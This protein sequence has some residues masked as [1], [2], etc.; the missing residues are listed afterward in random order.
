MVEREHLQRRVDATRA[1][2]ARAPAA[3]CGAVGR[4]PPAVPPVVAEAALDTRAMLI[5]VVVLMIALPLV[6]AF[7]IDFALGSAA[8]GLTPETRAFWAFI[9]HF[10]EARWSLWPTAIAAIGVTVALIR[11][12]DAPWRE[13]ARRA[14][15][16][17][18]FVFTAIAAPGLFVHVI[19]TIVGRARPRVTFDQAFYGLDPFAFGSAYA[20]YPSGHTVAAFALAFAIGCYSRV[21]GM[22]LLIP[23][24]LVGISRVALGP[25]WPG[26]VVAGIG[27]ALASTLL[28]RHAFAK[29][30]VAFTITKGARIAPL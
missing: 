8:R 30:G 23:A 6:M 21:A 25:H 26:D 15:H 18:M 24:A 5:A 29:A 19:K 14:L 2:L 22:A 17:C 11:D 12:P 16:F 3:I 7:T 9:T 4:R 10:G 13:D 1:A 27:L 20:S 28:L